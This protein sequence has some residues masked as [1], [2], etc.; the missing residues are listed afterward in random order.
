MG[1]VRVGIGVR[2]HLGIRGVLTIAR[3]GADG[4]VREQRTGENLVTTSGFSQIAAA[5]VWAGMQDQAA[6]LGITTPTYLTPLYGAVGSG[7]GTPTKADTALG[8]ELGRQQV[9]GA[10]STPASPTTPSAATWMFYFPNPPVTWT[11]TEA[12][13][14]A[15][16]TSAAG[17]G[18]LVDHWMFSPVLTVP[19]TDSLLLQVSLQFGP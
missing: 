11:V 12:G 1:R 13:V 18:T 7:T 3:I 9:G 19:P 4:R 15:G 6:G 2:E 8:A 5:L 10:G 14:F 16:A 17:S